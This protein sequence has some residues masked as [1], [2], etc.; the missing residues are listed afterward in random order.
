MDI[1][2]FYIIND[3]H[4]NNKPLKFLKLATLTSGVIF[5]TRSFESKRKEIQVEE[6]YIINYKYIVCI[7]HICKQMIWCGKVNNNL[8]R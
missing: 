1:H 2:I 3:K 7:V 5:V 4:H 6:I 8:F